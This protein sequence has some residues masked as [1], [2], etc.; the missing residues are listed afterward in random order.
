MNKDL[1]I[2]KL[3]DELASLEIHCNT[4]E[5]ENQKLRAQLASAK[6]I[7][8]KYASVDLY[9]YVSS[10]EDA[11][12]KVPSKVSALLVKQFLSLLEVE[13]VAVKTYKDVRRVDIET[14]ENHPVLTAGE[15]G[16][17]IPWVTIV[18]PNP[19]QEGGE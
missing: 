1:E 12:I 2:E 6:H 14:T 17:P 3:K 7:L 19:V 5:I 15:D 10:A 9:E 11:N 16:D 13:P 8:E 4:R 18:W